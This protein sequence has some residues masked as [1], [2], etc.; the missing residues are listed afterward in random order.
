MNILCVT[1]LMV[2]QTTFSLFGHK[3]FRRL[4]DESLMG[5]PR[6]TDSTAAGPEAENA[7]GATSLR[8][9]HQSLLSQRSPRQLR[10]ACADAQPGSDKYRRSHA[11][12]MGRSLLGRELAARSA[13]LRAV[14]AS[15]RYH[16][17]SDVRSPGLRA[18]T[19]VS[20][21]RRQDHPRRPARI[22]LS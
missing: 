10:Q 13:S 17:S 3:L 4:Y 19:V 15:G 7:S 1:K 11:A 14:S 22:I 8:A 16:R 12:G 9:A 5:S 2:I 6:S 18:G 20:S 21:A